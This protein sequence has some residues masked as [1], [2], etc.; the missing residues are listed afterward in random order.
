MTSIRVFY[1]LVLLVFF[2]FA[3]SCSS[4]S[5]QIAT[6]LGGAERV[7]V[8]A[9]KVVKEVDVSD[10]IEEIRVFP[11]K[12]VEGSML[13]DVEKILLMDEYMV[14][15]DKTE[16]KKIVVFD[17]KGDFVKELDI[18]GD[19]PDKLR[20]IIDCWIND[21][22]ELEVYDYAAQKILVYDENF[23][24]EKA[25]HAKDRILFH[26]MMSVPGSDGYVGFSRGY[27]GVDG[28]PF[29]LAFLDDEL[30]VQHTALPFDSLIMGA[31]ISLPISPFLRVGDDLR[32]YQDFDPRIY[33]VKPEGYLEIAYYLDYVRQPSPDDFERE[34]ILENLE[35]FIG[36]ESSYENRKAV[37]EGYTGFRGRWMES[38][39]YAVFDSF[40]EAHNSFFSV[41]HKGKK[42]ILAQ[43]HD[44]RDDQRYHLSLPTHFQAAD[45]EDNRFV[46][47]MPGW[48]LGMY[49]LPESPFYELVDQNPETVF[50]MEVLLK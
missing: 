30:A 26:S 19:G 50:V 6:D 21:H 23:E 46:V 41:Y 43:G 36:L 5:D 25:I 27:S 24:V 48:W 44:L 7:V 32:F 11:L 3:F 1:P 49:L 14:I 17:R 34:L 31:S 40:D 4:A 28:D 29:K 39:D 16:T 9:E 12:E 42:Q 8:D 20:Q 2:T 35:L 38:R 18:V 10:L 15:F 45:A 33:T 22:G 13:G 47:A 37:F